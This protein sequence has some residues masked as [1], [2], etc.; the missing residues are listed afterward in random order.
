MRSILLLALALAFLPVR[1]DIGEGNWDLQITTV[2]PGVP[3][4]AIRQSQCL[5]AADAK[6]PAK[7][8]GNPGQGCA[9]GNRSDSG[10]VFHFEIT[11]ERE[12]SALSGSGELRYTRDAIDGD[13]VMRV[14][15]GEQTLEVRTAV[16]AKRVGPCR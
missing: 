1:A 10:S 15:Q 7:L 8:L 14:K 5:S 13:I 9:F 12:G 2:I 3:P 4:N 11:C 16:K 6:D